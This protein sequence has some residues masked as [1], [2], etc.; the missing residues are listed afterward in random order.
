MC[1]C[2]CLYM[3]S[4]FLYFPLY[5][6]ISLSLVL[7]F[8]HSL[9]TCFSPALPLSSSLYISFSLLLKSCCIVFVLSRYR[10]IPWYIYR[11]MYVY[12]LSTDRCL[13]AID[14]HRHIPSFF[15]VLVPVRYTCLAVSIYLLPS[16][17]L[18]PPLSLSRFFSLDS[19]TP[20]GRANNPTKFC[21]QSPTL[22][23]R[24]RFTE[25]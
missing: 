18:A 23:G 11:F 17:A 7:S 19:A 3:F 24:P 21:M 25:A 13:S 6:D 15:P 5:D 12:P 20:K 4:M 1:V 22:R 14:W 2:I 16:L 10:D 9:V 8:S